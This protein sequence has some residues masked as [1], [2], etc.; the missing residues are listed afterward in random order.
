MRGAHT[1]GHA[2]VV[3]ADMGYG[4]DRA[5][6]GLEELAYGEIITA[7][8]YK[9][10]PERDKQLWHET[11][12]L[13]E[14]ISRLKPVPLI[15]PLLFGAMDRFQEIPP[16]YPRRDLSAPNVQLRAMYRIIRKGLGKHLVEKMMTRRM[17]M[18]STFPLPAFAAE[19]HGYTEEIY[20]VVCDADMSRAWAPLDPKRSKIRYFA[21]NGRVVERLKLYGVRSE[22]IFLTGFPL[23][24]RLV[25]T[26]D[27]EVVKDDLAKRICNLDPNGIFTH[28][29]WSVLHQELGL[30]RC[31]YA[32]RPRPV[33]ITFAVGGAGAQKQIGLDIAKSLAMKIRRKQMR[34]NLVAG[35]RQEV[36]QFFVRGLTALGL[37]QEIG[38]G[39]HVMYEPNRHKYFH[40]FDR[41]LRTTDVLWTKPSELSFYTGLGIPVIMT[42]PVGSQE[43]FNKLWLF[44]VGSGVMMQEPAMCREWLED[45][46]GS[47]G[48]ARL[49]WNGYLEAPTHGAHRIES[50]MTGEQI[51]IEK[52]PLI[53]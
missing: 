16:F 34:L 46:I 39:V 12:T 1:G 50:I 36:Q 3:S 18:V 53:V 7:N 17:P 25:G 52:L 37:K 22:H 28:H 44:N 23:P 15:G 6:H 8:K 5:A 35:T 40:H 43:E 26:A 38:K 47:G 29:Y 41:L 33:T 21:P 51:K 20:L 9:G 24:K 14:T 10:I 11:Q 4:H 31:T 48:L 13:Y 42:Q 19:E 45:W 49:A 2:W 32:I 27:G 30:D